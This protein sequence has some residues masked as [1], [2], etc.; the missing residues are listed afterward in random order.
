MKMEYLGIMVDLETAEEIGGIIS[1]RIKKTASEM[2][3]HGEF[4]RKD[5]IAELIW[6]LENVQ[7]TI[8]KLKEEK[9]KDK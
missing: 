8:T 6:Q 2:A 1:L 3:T 7:E 5:E 4:G 9:E